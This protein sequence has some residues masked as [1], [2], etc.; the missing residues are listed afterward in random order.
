MSADQLGTPIRSRSTWPVIRPAA[1][2]LLFAYAGSAHL[3]AQEDTAR[4]RFK[5]TFGLGAGM[6][7]FYGDIGFQ[8]RNYN[9]LLT[10]LGYEL[11]A[12]TP[13]TPWLEAS[14]YALHGRVGANERSPDRNL[15][16]ESRITVGGFQL[17]YNFHQFLNPNRSVEP[18]VSVGFESLEFLSKTDLFD[19]QGRRYHY[20]SDGTIRD[21]D[22]AAPNAAD[23]VLLQRDHTYESD[24]RELNLDGFGKYT[25]RTWAFPVGIGARMRFGG[26]VDLRI[27]TTM[28]FTTTDLIDGVTSSSIE[29]RRGDGRNDRFLYS[30]VSLNYAI[31]LDRRRKPGSKSTLRSEEIDLIAW[32]DDEDADGVPDW[33][34][35]CPHTPPGVKVDASGCPLDGDGDGVPDHLDQEPDTAP[36]AAVDAD[37]VTLSD[38]AL[39]KAWLNYKDSANV[40]I[41]TSRVESFGPKSGAAQAAKRKRAYVVQVGTQVEGISEELIQKILSI[42]D[43]RTIE[44]GDT[45]YYVVGNYDE[46]PEAVRR[47]LALGRQGIEGRVMAEENGRLSPVDTEGQTAADG[48]TPEARAGQVIIRVQLGA[49]RKRLSENIFAGIS[50]L[51]T[52]KGDDGLTRYYTGS[53]TDINQAAKHKVDMLMKGFNGAFLVAFKDGKRVSLK[54]AGARLTGPENLKELPKGGIDRKLIYFRVQV[55]TFAGNVPMDVMDKYIEVGDVVPVTS[56]DAVRYY[57]GRF[58]DRSEAEA[59]RRS[60]QEK[61]IMDAFVVGDVAGSIIPADEA[62]RLL[63]EP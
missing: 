59:A 56:T 61:G 47:Q 48:G 24:I 22:E 63:K 9:P 57:H 53:F 32:N 3:P 43:V 58:R 51:V 10:R 13:V 14:L 40:N 28:H 50:D 31:D 42:P 12:G 25:E 46:L 5:P 33:K 30:S 60:L 41:V 17:A 15:N 16:F 20:W 8:H 39:L 26:G 29:G 36:G 45:T 35:L 55:G 52:I 18:Y 4:F 38:D 7:A 21:I 34:D 54:E 6:F 27:G 11:R 23:A 2:L 1:L 37:G 44:R 62:E 49:F 19:A